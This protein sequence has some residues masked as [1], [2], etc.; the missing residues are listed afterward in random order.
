L[1]TARVKLWN[2][3]GDDADAL[4]VMLIAQIAGAAIFAPI[5]MCNL[6]TSLCIGVSALPFVHIAAAIALVE[7]R[8]LVQAATASSVW[9]MSV[10]AVMSVARLPFARSV[11]HATVICGALGTITLYYLQVE[12]GEPLGALCLEWFGPIG[13]AVT[14]ADRAS[15]AASLGRAWIQISTLAVVFLALAATTRTIV[16]ARVPRA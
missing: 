14:L 11:M 5:L 12:F 1:I 8:Q 16:V 10:A 2:H 4:N 7:T 13:A 3:G 6:R 9:L 15:S